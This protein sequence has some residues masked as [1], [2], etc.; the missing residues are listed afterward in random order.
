MIGA[1]RTGKKFEN[2]FSGIDEYNATHGTGF[3]QL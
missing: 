1:D 2:I 3:S